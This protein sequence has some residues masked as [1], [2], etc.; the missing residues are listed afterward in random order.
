MYRGEVVECVALVT[1]GGRGIGRGIVLALAEIGWNVVIN[2]AHLA[3]PANDTASE[4]RAKGVR[5]EVVQADIAAGKDRERLVSAVAEFFGRLDLLVNN[6]G[7][8]PERRV[9]LLE[10]SEA[11]FDRL[12]AT[13]LKGP[14]FLTQKVARWMIEQRRADPTCRPKIINVSSI[15][16]YTA[17]PSRGEYCVSKAGVSMMTLL[18]ATRLA[19]HG[20]GVYELRPGIMATD[21]TVGVRETYD[22]L[23]ANGLTPIA[24]W[25][26]PEDVGKAVVAIAQDLLPFSTGEVINV[27]GGFHIHRL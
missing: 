18:Y 5:A 11:S 10:S 22:R 12:I 21:M 20:I 2:Y 4:A 27:D 15:S 9:D 7:V 25:G 23:I 3:E 13:N 24:R 26:T 6:A 1:G 19:E 17:S 14:Y 8:A 16:A